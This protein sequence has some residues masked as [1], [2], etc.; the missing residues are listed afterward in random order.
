MKTSGY[1]IKYEG[2]YLRKVGGDWG[3]SHTTVKNINEAYVFSKSEA[4]N[5]W[6]GDGTHEI[7]PVIVKTL[8]RHK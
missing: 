1:V 5:V 3:L 4:E 7:L 2:N 6:Y 8:I